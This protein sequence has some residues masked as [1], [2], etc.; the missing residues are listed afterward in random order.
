[1]THA[2]YVLPQNELVGEWVVVDGYYLTPIIPD[3]MPSPWV[4]G[5]YAVS[6]LAGGLLFMLAITALA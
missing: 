1:M 5:T 6:A 3:S 4:D 2:P